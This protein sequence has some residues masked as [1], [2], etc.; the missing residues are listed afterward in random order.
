MVNREKRSLSKEAAVGSVW[1]IIASLMQR[2]GGLVFTII[3]ARFLLPEGFGMYN[4]VIAAATI[5]FTLSQTG[6]NKTLVLY[7][8]EALAKGDK[9]LANSYFNYITKVKLIVV[10]I[11]FALLIAL[12]YP[13]AHIMF[14]NDSLF[15]PILLAGLFTFLGTLEQFY[16]SFFF[17][18]RRVGF[19]VYKETIFQI[20]R[21]G[22]VLL[23]F[24]VIYKTPSVNQTLVSLIIASFIILALVYNKIRTISP[25]L[26]SKSGIIDK[27]TKGRI[28]SFAF[29]VTL[30]S[31][32]IVFVGNIDTLMLGWL[33][34][35]N[36]YIGIYSSAFIL[37]ASVTGLLA[38]G[39]VFLPIFVEAGKKKIETVFNK[40][41]KYSMILAMPSAFGLASLGSY[42][43]VLI[44]GR[45]Y[46]EGA[47][48]LYFLSSLIVLSVYAGLFAE[49]F[50]SK[51]RAKDYFLLLLGVIIIDIILNY[52]F[53]KGFAHYSLQWAITG[54]AIASVI[55]WVI[56]CIGL[57]ITA[58]RNLGIK[59]QLAGTL[60]KTFIASVCMT[61][62]IYALRSVFVD[63]NLVKGIIVVIAAIVTYIIAITLVGG[64]K[65]SD[66]KLFYS[67]VRDK[68]AQAKPAA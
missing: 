48:P 40:T 25:Y 12:A 54:A 46:I 28:L 16:I 36:A 62:V 67:I 64:M 59:L 24:L 32:S 19:T 58:R 21:I 66:Y 27:V 61:V 47:L 9:K 1:N 14:N 4:L 41:F 57:D 38:F 63:L 20:I 42:F 18:V 51:E 26:F 6:I 50:S 10:L 15:V 60:L 55:S 49:L 43:L 35:D 23:F 8:S 22:L 68:F 65:K 13:I 7:L 17:V 45:D 44:Y 53:I 39:H 2:A 34:K 56:Y 30:S 29:Y 5:F 33:I 11:I 31:V 3:I 52:F 37:V